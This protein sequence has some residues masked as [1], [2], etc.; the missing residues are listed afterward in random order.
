MSRVMWFRSLY[1]RIAF[2]FVALLAVLLLAQTLLFLWLTGRIDDTPQG[3]TPQQLAD[4]VARE[5]SDALS[6]NPEI[7]IESH[8][9]THFA[10]IKRPFAVMMRDGR[11]A[12]NRAEALP[13]G[14]PPPGPRGQR[15][16]GRSGGRGGPGAS[17]ALSLIHI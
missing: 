15:P 14:F 8:V 4:F 2:G 1:L 13:R 17:W 3:R 9:R 7:D 12:S 5:L 10:E 16:P 11:R 6:A